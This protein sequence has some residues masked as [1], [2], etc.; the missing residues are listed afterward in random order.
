VRINGRYLDDALDGQRAHV[1]FRNELDPVVVR[2][3][4]RMDVVMPM[5][6]GK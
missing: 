6:R 4:E 1:E 3:G 2:V 5:R